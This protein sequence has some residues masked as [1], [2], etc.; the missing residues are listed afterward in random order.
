[1]RKGLV[2]SAENQIGVAQFL[3][4]KQRQRSSTDR[5][6]IALMASDLIKTDEVVG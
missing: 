1:M 6:I 3:L 2:C 4:D 5:P